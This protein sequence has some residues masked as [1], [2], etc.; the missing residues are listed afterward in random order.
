ME[1]QPAEIHSHLTRESVDE[2]NSA[3]G[4]R[5]NSRVSFLDCDQLESACSTA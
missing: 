2:M 3:C 4:D 5:K 1:R